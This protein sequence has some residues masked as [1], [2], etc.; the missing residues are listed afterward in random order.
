MR[1]CSVLNYLIRAII[2]ANSSSKHTLYDYVRVYGYIN[3]PGILNSNAPSALTPTNAPSPTLAA[4]T[5]S[6]DCVTPPADSFTGASAATG[7]SVTPTQSPSGG[8]DMG[9]SGSGSGGGFAAYH[10]NEPSPS[11]STASCSSH[12][13]AHTSPYAYDFDQLHTSG[14]TPISPAA[15]GGGVSAAL[16]EMS[17]VV[18]SSGAGAGAAGAV[19]GATG[20]SFERL[21][22]DRPGEPLGG[23]GAR[24]TSSSRVRERGVGRPSP[25]SRHCSM[26]LVLSG[27][28]QQQ[29]PP[30]TASPAA[31]T[32]AGIS[33]SSSSTTLTAPPPPSEKEKSLLAKRRTLKTTPS[34]RTS[35][36]QVSLFSIGMYRNRML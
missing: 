32:A 24:R 22:D 1:L 34:K 15:G 2:C 16:I 7:S 12:S 5:F 30:G 27:S 20:R 6:S 23:G 35:T 8:F 36:I 28:R 26:P 19:A 3:T 10:Q 4:K 25:V 21:E 11:A 29:Q 13:G 33:A 14:S 17:E 18:S 9:C 31:A